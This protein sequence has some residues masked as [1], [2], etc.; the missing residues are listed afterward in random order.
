MAVLSSAGRGAR[1]RRCSHLR[2]LASMKGCMPAT[3]AISR[4]SPAPSRVCAAS[5]STSDA[6]GSSPSRDL[7][8]IIG[9]QFCRVRPCRAR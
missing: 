6:V 2:W 4:T 1:T 7:R 9:K 8:R 3:G 5:A